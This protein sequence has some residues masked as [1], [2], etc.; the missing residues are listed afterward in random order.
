MILFSKTIKNPFLL[1]NFKMF[2]TNFNKGDNYLNDEFAAT[3]TK[4]NQLQVQL[5]ET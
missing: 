5:L 1:N 4:K 3:K 2:S